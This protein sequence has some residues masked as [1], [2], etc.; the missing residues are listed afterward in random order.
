MFRELLERH[1]F[2]G[3]ERSVPS[4]RDPHHGSSGTG[5]FDR[6]SDRAHDFDRGHHRPKRWEY[7][8]Y[9]FQ[10]LKGKERSTFW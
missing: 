9:S 4:R 2:A 7:S 3:T 1:L 10:Q 5:R 6:H 8:E